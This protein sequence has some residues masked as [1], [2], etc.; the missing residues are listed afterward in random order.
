M[1][2]DPVRD[3]S[4]ERRLP[5]GLTRRQFLLGSAATAASGVLWAGCAPPDPAE[6]EAQ[7]RLRVSSDVLTAF[8]NWY[9]SGCQGC[10]AGCGMIVRVI[11]GRAKKIEGN[12]SHP[13]NNGKMCV[14][15]LSLVQAQY[16][17]DR[18]TG[19]MRQNGPRGQ[20]VFSPM[21]WNDALDLL[22]GQLG[23]ISQ[24]GRTRDVA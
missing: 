6:F 1:S 13:V 10:G 4:A 11:E 3:Q 15:A 24:S 17:P 19:P 14:R 5:G 9:A 18:F 2:D 21:S 20:G 22:V 12:P 16:N 7:S 8:E 23:N